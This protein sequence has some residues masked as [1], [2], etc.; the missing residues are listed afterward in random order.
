MIRGMARA[1]L[2]G[3]ALIALAGEALAQDRASAEPV[4]DPA[5]GRNE[6]QQAGQTEAGSADNEIVITARRRSETTLTAPVSVTALSGASLADAGVRRLEELAIRVPNFRQSTG[7]PNNFNFIRGVGSGS[8]AGFEQAVGVFVDEI[9]FGRGNQAHLPFFDMQQVEVLRGPQV[10]FFGNS[11]TGGAISFTTRR[12]G[13]EFAANAD[14][15]YE[16]NNRELVLNAGVDLPV[17]EQLSARLAV[18]HQDLDRGWLKSVVNGQDTTEPRY[19]NTGVRAII[20]Y[21]P[22]D[23]VDVLF[24]AEYLDMRQLGNVLQPVTNILNNPAIVETVFDDR[25]VVGRPA[26]FSGLGDVRNLEQQSYLLRGAVE[27]G[28]AELILTTGY[29]D[30]NFDQ[31]IEADLTPLPIIDYRQDERYRQFSQEI[32]LAGPITDT[33]DYV[34]GGYFQRD[35]LDLD[36]FIEAN[37]PP[38]QFTGGRRARL[39]QRS[40]TASAFA[41]FTLRPLD[42]LEI[43]AGVRYSNVRKRADQSTVP[44]NVVTGVPNPALD[45]PVYRSLFGITHSFTGLRQQQDA[46]MPQASVQYFITPSTMLF[47]RFVKGEKSGGFDPLYADSNPAL[48]SFRPETA[49]SYE[50]GFKGSFADDT[51]TLALTAFYT[52]LDD[53]QVSTFNGSTNYVVGN[54]A[55]ARSQ[56]FELEATWRPVP[57][58]RISGVAGYTDFEYVSFTGAGCTSQQ[59]VARPVGCSQDLSGRTGPFVSRFTGTL[60]AAWRQPVGPHEIEIGTTYNYRSSY[61]PSPSLDPLL[62]QDGFG[63]LDARLEFRAADG[64]RVGIFGRNLTNELFAEAGADVPGIRG[65]TYLTTSRRRQIGIQAGI[66][67]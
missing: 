38:A 12:P 19:R 55:R 57:E 62:Q 49:T 16:L 14:A 46:F 29:V 22:A 43:T 34:I 44:V 66:D 58:L 21:A 18:F 45:G 13:R 61:N 26:P 33:F 7:G 60:N 32:R 9:Y 42:G 52:D 40:T 63:L 10:L 59:N 24:K 3:V 50:G 47:A 17:N 15:S 37:V 53:L 27:I 48:A 5:E 20:D 64:W 25:R 36:I 23:T 2:G 1:W 30:Y 11:T 51:V 65:A 39:D 8:N 54:A 56:G 41:N 31:T 4:G 67:W 35:S 6:E 28:T